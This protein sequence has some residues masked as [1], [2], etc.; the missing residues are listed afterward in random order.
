MAFEGVATEVTEGQGGAG[1]ARSWRG[2]RLP[3]P[4][5]LGWRRPGCLWRPRSFTSSSRTKASVGFVHDLRSPWI[6][7]L[8]SS[9]LS[10]SNNSSMLT[11][12]GMSASLPRYSSSKR[13]SIHF[14]TSSLRCSSRRSYLTVTRACRFCSP[15]GLPPGPRARDGDCSL[16][17]T[18][19]PSR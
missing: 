3:S 7:W 12:S 14:S 13:P 15:P 19:L 10:N 1:R 2:L 18:L 6:F 4:E 8:L 5:G 9:S 17:S 11:S 16:L